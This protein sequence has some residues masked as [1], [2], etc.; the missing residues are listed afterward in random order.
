MIESLNNAGLFLINTLFDL[1]ILLLLV[2]LLLAYS[3]ANYFNPIVNMI[4]KL[5]QPVIRPLRKFLP[6]LYGIELSTVVAIL[7]FEFLKF[8]FISV[9]VI[10][11][12]N[13]AGIIL[14]SCAD[15]LKFLLNIF[16]YGI[17]IQAILSWIQIG[18][19]PIAD[20]LDKITAPIMRPLRRM[21]PLV[22]GFDISPIP[23]LILLQLIIILFINPFYAMSMEM[24]FGNII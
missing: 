10:G 11:T 1:Y 4:I 13:F 23:A 18:Y 7:L 14:L 6:T 8:I 20:V 21:I 24:A 16:F 22:G 17:F 3:Q 2:R 19:S 15:A 5:T 9:I 12:P